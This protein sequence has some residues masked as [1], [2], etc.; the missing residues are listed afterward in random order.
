M[1]GWYVPIGLAI[2]VL[3]TPENKVP[4]A[5]GLYQASMV[6]G[7]RLWTAHGWP[8]GRPLRLSCTILVFSALTGICM[9]GIYFINAQ[10]TVQ[11]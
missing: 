9:L 3:I 8:Y 5:M 11:T 1:L 2:I 6:M 10:S 4:W 7:P